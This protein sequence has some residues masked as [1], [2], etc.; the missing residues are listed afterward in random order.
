MKLGLAVG[1]P[2][3]VVV[4]E[5]GSKSIGSCK[6][7]V[8]EPTRTCS[9]LTGAGA[10]SR[11]VC[12]ACSTVRIL[13]RASVRSGVIITYPS[14]YIHSGDHRTAV[15]RSRTRRPSHRCL[16]K[17]HSWIHRAQGLKL[18]VSR[19]T[20]AY[21][22]VRRSVMSLCKHETSRELPT[23]TCCLPYGHIF[24]RRTR[25]KAHNLLTTSQSMSVSERT[26]PYSRRYVKSILHSHDFG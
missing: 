21:A 7:E 6:L 20:P 18:R 9:A 16:A 11:D 19:K 26:T 23:E 4:G 17:S 3:D 12:M 15:W 24:C 5:G 13:R 8:I 25:S 10:L 22:Y 14:T 1:A 2:G